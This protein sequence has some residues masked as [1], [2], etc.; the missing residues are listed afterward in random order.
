MECPPARQP[1]ARPPHLLSIRPLSPSLIH[2]PSGLIS[3]RPPHLISMAPQGG[4]QLTL[5]KGPLNLQ[6]SA[7]PAQQSSV[8]LRNAQAQLLQPAVDTHALACMH[9]LEWAANAAWGLP[10]RGGGMQ[11]EEGRRGGR[12]DPF[13]ALTCARCHHCPPA[14]CLPTQPPAACHLPPAAWH[15]PTSPSPTSPP[16]TSCRHR[17]SAP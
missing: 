17:M 16:P 8:A 6:S 7:A 9:A 1:F 11:Q 4:L 12:W 14:I 2:P 10:R 5:K 15:Q 3:I 13:P